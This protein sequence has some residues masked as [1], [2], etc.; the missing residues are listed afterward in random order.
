MFIV[1]SIVS[2]LNFFEIINIFIDC[3]IHPAAC[4][5]AIP[6]L[7]P[8]LTSFFCCRGTFDRNIAVGGE[9]AVGLASALTCTSICLSVHAAH[10][11]ILAQY[12]DF[13]RVA[14]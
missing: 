8:F 10:R 7:V 4:A 11:T 2:Y 1:L 6:G 3:V 9:D 12:S 13:H 5:L 14:D